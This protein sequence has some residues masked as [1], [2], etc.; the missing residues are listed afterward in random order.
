MVFE[1]FEAIEV[2]K[3]EYIAQSALVLYM[4]QNKFT[5]WCKNLNI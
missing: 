5:L 1:L 3:I 2:I 4:P